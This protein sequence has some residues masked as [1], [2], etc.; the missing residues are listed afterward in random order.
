[1][2]QKWKKI[3]S[4]SAPIVAR[5]I[6][7][8]L[9]IITHYFNRSTWEIDG[10]KIPKSISATIEW[11]KWKKNILEQLRRFKITRGEFNA[12]NGCP[13]AMSYCKI[14]LF[15]CLKRNNFHRWCL[16]WGLSNNS[17]IHIE[18]SSL[19]YRYPNYISLISCE[20]WWIVY[21]TREYNCGH[22]IA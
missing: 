15:R 16:H 21:R 9:K 20:L 11:E 10:G 19:Q 12:Q 2:F 3:F 18:C 1:M 7:I 5:R 13:E 17:L 22:S 14:S 6:W 8:L 4:F